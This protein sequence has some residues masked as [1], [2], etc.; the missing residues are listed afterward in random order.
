[1]KKLTLQDMKKLAVERDGEFLSKE[2]INS[3]IKHRWRCSEG[4][5]WEASPEKIRYG[6][7]C[8]YCAHQ[9][10]LTI[11]EMHQL[12]RSQGGKCLSNKYVN[13]RTKLRWQCAKGHKWENSPD[14]VKNRSQWCRV[15]AG[16]EKLT[17]EE[18]H[19][20][21]TKRGGKCLSK[22]YINHKTK[23]VWQ[24]KK[25]HQ[26]EA[27]P[28][29]I[30]N[31]GTW[32]PTCVGKR[33]SIEELQRLA[34]K[35]GGRCLSKKYVSSVANLAWQ[36]NHGHKWK[37][38][39][40]NIR[41]GQWCP[42]CMNSTSEDICKKFF[43][44][45]FKKKFPKKRPEWLINSDGNRMELDGHCE[46]LMLAFE[47]NGKQHYEKNLFIKDKDAINR[48]IK[49]D[50]IK[51]WLCKKRGIS[52]IVVSYKVS[53][54]QMYDFIISTCRK[55]KI[56]IPVHEKPN[57]KDFT[58]YKTDKIT[59]LNDLVRERGGKCLSRNYINETE[60]LQWKCKFG[61]EWNATP[62]TIRQGHWC[63]SCSGTKKLTLADMKKLAVNRG[64]K[65]L[66]NK[67]VNA[68]SKLRWQCFQGHVWETTPSHIRSKG[69]WCPVCA[70]QKRR[71]G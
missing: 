4:H 3:K 67:Y 44:H 54:S 28:V 26:W 13:A 46:E 58:I 64:G 1:M 40:A 16:K 11:E 7:W 63:L 10:P 36:C 8:P 68:Q 48:R 29:D 20:I 6:R 53:F 17:I 19:K 55:G 56:S 42:E 45:I 24:C 38:R 12:A 65:C 27:P 52:L 70:M 41:Q 57:Y 71:K 22:K 59:E 43:E 30:R 60:P 49:D 62:N 51:Q 39:P 9:I 15:C 31:K 23:L 25:R 66:S 37:A 47:Y 32:C 69:S 14:Q 5:E 50:E 34:I 18:M 35:R 61:H 21:A 2:Y 33:P